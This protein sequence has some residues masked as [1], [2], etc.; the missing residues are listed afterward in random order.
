MPRYVILHHRCPAG[1]ER[2]THWD[3]MLECEGVLL[4]WALPE[5]PA[6][7]KTIDAEKLAEHRLDYLEYEGPISAGR[8][9]VSRWD[10][11]QYELVEQ[12]ES[13]MIAI[14]DGR[15]GLAR[16]T[17][18]QTDDQLQSWRFTG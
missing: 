12:S 1:Y 4:T 13:G 7:G 14:L 18:E 6:Q 10:W 11:G 17:L 15:Q 2:P 8:G 5:R 3:L 9:E 16:A